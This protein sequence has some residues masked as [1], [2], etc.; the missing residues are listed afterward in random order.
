MHIRLMASVGALALLLTASG[1]AGTRQ[2]AAIVVLPTKFDTA[3]DHL[4]IQVGFDGAPAWCN[5]DTGWSALVTIDRI[6]ARTVGL[7]ER[8]GMPTP[9]GNPPNRDDGNTVATVT[10]GPVTFPDHQV[11]VRD[12]PRA[13]SDME[14]IV[15]AALLRNYVVE[16]DHVTPRVTLRDR[17]SY[18]PPKGSVPV[19]LIVR[20]NPNVPFVQATVALPDG[21]R[22]QV[23][24]VVDTGA[25]YY[26]MALIPPVST[27]L[28]SRLRT[29]VRPDH[30]QSGG[31]SVQLVA[32][33][34]AA[35]IVGSFQ[36]E[37]PV[38]ALVESGLSRS[39][40]D[41]LLGSGFLKRFTIGFD[42]EAR[43]MYLAPNVAFSDQQRFDASGVGFIRTGRGYVVQVVVT[44]SPAAHAGVQTGDALVSIDGTSA[45]AITAMQ[46]RDRLTRDGHTTVLE[47]S[48][49]G[50]PV[51][52]SFR[53]QR[54]L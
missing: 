18:V 29:A 10:F 31:G 26:A 1:V 2:H 14:C 3:T 21:T 19:P 54:R 51:H 42:F 27:R 34:P 43:R 17:S 52:V 45:A 37:A 5:L 50:A 23:Q 53:L 39:N 41:G 38:V 25:A 9:D 32:A 8:P 30:P 12:L 20:T 36:L 46:L 48:R 49:R 15:G 40:D 33:R 16:V 22:E 13:E 35:V 47:L 24:T 44:D 28:R 7:N 6:K 4:L 11:I